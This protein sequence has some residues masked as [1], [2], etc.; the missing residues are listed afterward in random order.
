MSY[1]WLPY[2]ILPLYAGLERIPDSL[3]DASGDLGGR[4]WRTFRSVVLPMALPGDRR[5][6]DLHVLADAR[7]LHHAAARL[8]HAVHRQRRLRERRH[9]EQ[10][11]ARLGVRDGPDRDHARVP[12]DRAPAR[13]VRGALMPVSGGT[14][15]LLRIGSAIT[16]AFL[17][18]PLVV[19][20]I[21]AFNKTTRAGVAAGG[22]LVPLV[23]GRRGTT[24]A[25]A[26]RCGRASRSRSARPRSRW[27]S[28]RSPSY[29]VARY[30]FF[31]KT[32][33]SFLVILPIALPGHRHRH[34]AERDV[35]AGARR[36][37]VAVD[38]DHRPRDVLHR[39]RL[40]QRRRAAAA[41]ARLARGRG[42]RPRRAALAR[43]SCDITLP[44]DALG[45]D[46][47][48]AARLRAE[49]RRGD[50]HDVH[51]GRDARRCRSGSST[52]SAARGTSAS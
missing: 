34:G 31:G 32:S 28:A 38:G 44:A 19:I 3:L 43:R 41:H 48:R 8:E 46:R 2:M 7:R 5:R 50:R 23:L 35:H 13:R 21:Y 11:A 20:F 37:P 17:Y 4:P 16:L 47:R 6:L 51:R 25:C 10:P 39:R 42:R 1:L 18:A 27:S 30:D 49:L 52:T 29:T 26:T 45:A 15:W 22:P 40:Q 33:I 24:R 9:R 36:E 14:R 12:P